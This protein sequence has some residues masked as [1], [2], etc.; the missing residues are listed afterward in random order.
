M[1]V[2]ALDFDGVLC[3]SAGEG[4]VSAWRAGGK[5]WPEWQGPEPLE[6]CKVRF[7]RLRPVVE[8]GYQMTLLM[9][10]IC[11][12]V[13]DA[14]IMAGFVSLCNGLMSA[15]GLTRPQLA[16]LFGQA[17]DEWIAKDSADW[18]G[19]H[20]FYAGVLARLNH[21]L[22][23]HPVYILT[24]KQ[25]RF[26]WQLLNAGGAVMPRERIFGFERNLS[27]AQMLDRVMAEPSLR[28]ARIHFV[29]D[30]VE[31]LFDMA[32]SP[33]QDAVCLYLADWGYNTPE[34]RELARRHP[35][36]TVWTIDQFLHI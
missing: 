31:T 36:V 15:H 10:L 3:D 21:A 29:E 33:R 24:T 22:G 32:K 14:E 11:D 25:E 2:F 26:A 28:G 5:I 12:N 18:L 6:D 7:V 19:R 13:S 30:R 34:Q 35:R 16:N 8:T 27:K 17:R 23:S 20:R 9:K 4:A 1:D